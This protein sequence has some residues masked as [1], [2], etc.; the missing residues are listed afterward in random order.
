MEPVSR[1]FGYD[2]GTPVDRYY[3]D[4]FLSK[5]SSDIRGS[6]LEIGD[7][8]YTRKFGGHRVTRTDVFHA[9]GDNPQA[10]IVGDLGSA[11]LVPSNTFDCAIVPQTLQFILDPIE[12]LR[13]LHRILRPGGVLLCT[14]P[15]LTVV[16][17][18]ADE[19]SKLWLWSFTPALISN[20]IEQV[21]SPELC[22]LEIHGNVKSSVCSLQG[23]SVEDV[24]IEALQ[25]YDPEFPVLICFRCEKAA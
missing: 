1:E 8:T 14:V 9:H 6:V 15:A 3:I 10:T 13:T 4:L 20:L 24:G 5:Y 11:P 18:N 23:L 22:S 19:W 17:S 7:D 12:G 25:P 2:R 21:F 16:S